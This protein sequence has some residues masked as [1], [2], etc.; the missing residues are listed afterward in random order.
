MITSLLILLKRK[1]SLSCCSGHPVAGAS[2]QGGISNSVI[3]GALAL[4]MAMLVVMLF[5]VNNVLRKVAKA[6][7]IEVAPK[8]LLLH[9]ESIC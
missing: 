3:L 7:G 2:D 1:L 8:L 6:N 4:V 5:L 9:W